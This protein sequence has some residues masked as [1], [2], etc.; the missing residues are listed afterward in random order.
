MLKA[1]L[2][3]APRWLFAFYAATAAFCAYFAMYSFRKPFAVG[4]FEGAEAIGGVD[5]KIAI[6]ISQVIGYALSKFIGIKVIAELKHRRRPWLMI[7]F[8]TIALLALVGFG[9]SEDSAWSLFW[10]FLNGLPLGMIWGVVFSYLEGRRNTEVLG[11][12]LCASFIVASGAVKSIGSWLMLNGIGEYWMP[13]TVALIF[14]PIIVLFTYLL[15]QLPEPDEADIAERTRREPMMGP[16][17][18]AFVRQ[19]GLGLA[20]LVL[21]Y[22]GLTA[23]RDFRD[24][25]FAELLIALGYAG[26]PAMFTLT[27][28][29]VAILVLVMFAL[30]MFIRNNQRALI[31]YCWIILVGALV[32][33]GSTWAYQAGLLRGDWWLVLTGLGLFLGYVPFNAI[34][35]DRLI[36]ALGSVA[37]AGFLIYVADAAGYS[38][39]IGVLLYKNFGSAELSWLN[40]FIQMSYVLAGMGVVFILGAIWYWR[41]QFAATPLRAAVNS[42]T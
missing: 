12:G 4:T 20:L 9:L 24:N 18:R 39:S 11:A 40:F 6:I 5:F 10:L 21:Y 25:F 38:G 28:L 29:P 37:T 32:V 22:V 30:T 41:K 13:A 17:R 27:E 1:Y 26:K 15:E 3:S 2:Q 42:T 34:L 14:L 33:G 16:E 36:A 7:G 31:L 19:F 35:F 23:Y 8:P